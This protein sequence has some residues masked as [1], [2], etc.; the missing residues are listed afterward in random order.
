[1]VFSLHSSHSTAALV[2]DAR[3]GGHGMQATDPFALAYDPGSQATRPFPSPSHLYPASHCTVMFNKA[4]MYEPGGTGAQLVEPRP[5]FLYP[6]GHVLQVVFPS[7]AWNR[8]SPHSSMVERFGERRRTVRCMAVPL[9]VDAPAAGSNQSSSGAAVRLG[10]PTRSDPRL[11]ARW[12][13]A[14][15]DADVPS[16]RVPL[17]WR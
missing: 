13:D 16:S 6:L 5:V 14:A 2:A 1:M 15:P 7:N 11:G 17:S 9:N 3:P 12:R 10:C 4:L 8:P